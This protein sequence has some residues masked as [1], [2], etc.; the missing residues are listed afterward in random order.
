MIGGVF[1]IVVTAAYF[2]AGFETIPQGVEEA[3]GSIKTV[4]KTVVLSVTLA[5]VFY[6]IMLFA[7]GF[8]WPW[9]EFAL[10][11]RPAA[12][13]MFKHLYPGGVGV[14]L[15]WILTIGA[16]AG[17]FTT[18]NG[19]F[20]ASANM[21]M[22]MGR[23]KL[24]P[25]ALAYQNKNG[26]AVRGQVICLALSLIGPLLGANLIDTITCFSA[27]AFILSWMVTC[28]SLVALRKKYPDLKRPYKIPGGIGMGIFAS[29]LTTGVFVMSFIPKSPFFGGSLAIKMMIGW[30]ALGVILFLCSA[31]HRK[32]LSDEEL[33]KGVFGARM[34]NKEE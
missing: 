2:L 10:M 16:I 3:G 25:K 20:T 12:A 17:L 26:V 21:F 1:A 29:V 31:P 27:L 7:F 13:T 6:A 22:S 24:V 11:E 33:E 30:M 8:G 18:W 34:G 9:Q 4:G 32:G 28:W 15:Y 23:G 5:C 14:A 19:F